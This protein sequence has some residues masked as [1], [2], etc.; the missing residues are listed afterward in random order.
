MSEQPVRRMKRR[1]GKWIVG[2]EPERFRALKLVVMRVWYLFV[3]ALGVVC[4]HDG[5][6]RPELMAAKNTINREKVVLQKMEDSL[7][8]ERRKIESE[9]LAIESDIDS[10]YM[11][12]IALYAQIVDSLRSERLLFDRSLPGLRRQADSLRTVL[13]ELQGNLVVSSTRMQERQTTVDSLKARR[14]VVLDSIQAVNEQLVSLSDRWDRLA[15]PDKYRKN[16]AL[17]PG[18]GNFPNRDQLPRRGE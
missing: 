4:A 10:T 1:D 17:V 9:G 2:D 8:A 15:N 3:P 14:V 16:T 13:A 7:Q 6:V 11:P 12:Q 18:P 5:Y